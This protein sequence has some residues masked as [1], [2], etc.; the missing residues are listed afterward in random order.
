MELRAEKNKCY[1]FF[2]T[3][4]QSRGFTYFIAICIGM[5]TSV[6]AMDSYPI[7]PGLERSIEYVNLVFYGIFVIEMGCKMIGQ[8]IQ[9]YFKES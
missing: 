6:L 9:S 5:N 1:R 7:E 3:I 2:L 8:G 4:I